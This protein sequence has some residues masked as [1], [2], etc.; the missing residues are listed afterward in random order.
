VGYP[1]IF[2]WLNMCFGELREQEIQQSS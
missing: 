1:I 2:S